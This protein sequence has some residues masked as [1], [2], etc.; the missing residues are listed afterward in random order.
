MLWNVLF[1][2]QFICTLTPSNNV[3]HTKYVSTQHK[4]IR[5]HR[6][7]C[8]GNEDDCN[9][10][11]AHFVYINVW[12]ES[13]TAVSAETNRKTHSIRI[14][15][16]ICLLRSFVYFYMRLITPIGLCSLPRCRT[17]IGFLLNLWS[18]RERERERLWVCV[19]WKRQMERKWC[20]RREI[21]RV[22]NTW[23]LNEYVF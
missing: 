16:D 9:C 18:E 12:L 7:Q 4:H 2:F 11:L 17:R 20:E 3:S 23:L 21:A 1:C 19:S 5:T 10:L 22:R 8:N 14:A 13:T 15:N 6:K